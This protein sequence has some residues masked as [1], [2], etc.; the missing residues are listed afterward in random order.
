MWFGVIQCLLNC[1]PPKIICHDTYATFGVHGDNVLKHLSQAC[2]EA[3]GEVFI[4]VPIVKKAKP[5]GPDTGPCPPPPTLDADSLAT[6]LQRSPEVA[7]SLLSVV[8]GPLSQYLLHSTSS[9]HPFLSISII[10]TH[11][12]GL[13]SRSTY[14]AS[15]P[16]KIWLET[17]LWEAFPDTSPT[18]QPKAT[19]LFTVL[20]HTPELPAH[21]SVVVSTFV[22]GS[23]LFVSVSP[24]QTSISRCQ[25]LCSVYLY[26]LAH[27]RYSILFSYMD[28]EWSEGWL[29]GGKGKRKGR[30]EGGREAEGREEW[31]VWPR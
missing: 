11:P 29:D 28:E 14:P 25:G 4:F 19:T 27:H 15:L 13:V 7:L 8:S 24:T 3:T 17:L 20:L 9:I 16:F 18:S 6:A 1:V 22:Y 26:H 2:Y 31:R 12:V 10:T 30:R 23:I 5:L 21:T